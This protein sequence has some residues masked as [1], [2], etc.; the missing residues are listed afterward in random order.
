MSSQQAEYILVLKKECP[1]CVLVEP[2][3]AELRAAGRRLQIWSQ[4]DPDFP[5]NAGEVGEAPAE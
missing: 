1:T 3:I 5:A 4:D 2:V